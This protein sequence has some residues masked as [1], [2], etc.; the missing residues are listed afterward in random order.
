MFPTQS[1]ARTNAPPP[2]LRIVPVESVLPHETH[3]DQRSGPLID[4][5]RHAE[6]MINPPIVAPLD[7]HH[8][9]VLDGAN[10][11]H[12]FRHLEYPHILVQVAHY[13]SGYVDLLT[14]QH[15]LSGWNTE[16]LID[17]LNNLSTIELITEQSPEAI[18]HFILPDARVFALNAQV[19]STH[20]RNAILR[21]V[22]GIYQHHATLNRTAMSEPEEIW[23]L[24]PD[25]LA[26]VIFQHY[27]PADIIAAARYQAYLPPGISRHII[28]GRALRVNYP[29]ARLRDPY[30][31][32]E[33]K[34]IILK[35]WVQEKIA[36]RQVR[37]YAEATYQFDE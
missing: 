20:E 25:A 6:V 30:T 3:D 14:W 9:V 27:T 2:D 36:H 10:R 5:L 15:I 31:D 33:K 37:Y 7:E 24:Y 18:A 17:H 19:T 1:P 11:C 32:I 34:N 26:L 13:D 21:D 29:M 8:F 16:S 23:P 35:T 4:N 22:V 12:T 28:H